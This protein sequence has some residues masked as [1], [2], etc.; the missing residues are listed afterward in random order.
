[1]SPIVPFQ[2][3][4]DRLKITMRTFINLYD[5]YLLSN[6]GQVEKRGKTAMIIQ[7]VPAFETT[8]RSVKT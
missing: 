2:P 3:V 6:G 1:M 8:C 4:L 7:F 5:Q